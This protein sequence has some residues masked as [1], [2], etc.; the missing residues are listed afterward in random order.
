[1]E[2]WARARS[3]RVPQVKVG[4]ISRKYVCAEDDPGGFLEVVHVVYTEQNPLVEMALWVGPL[5]AVCSQ[6][7]YLRSC[8]METLRQHQG[9]G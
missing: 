5:G 6:N 2:R 1:M 4:L 9:Q 7:S 8:Y 3:C